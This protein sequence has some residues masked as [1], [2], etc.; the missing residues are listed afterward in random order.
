MKQN[1]IDKIRH[2]MLLCQMRLKSLQPHIENSD[3]LSEIY[4]KVLIEKAI[5]KNDLKQENLTVLT[6]FVNKF[7]KR[8][9]KQIC[10]YFN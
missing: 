8:K 6:K 4:N 9:E 7:F 3:N 2:A 1:E 5:L 10:D